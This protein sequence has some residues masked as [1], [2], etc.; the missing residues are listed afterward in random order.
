MKGIDMGWL[1]QWGLGLATALVAAVAAVIA[2]GGPSAL[3]PK[4]SINQPFKDQDWS[5]LP[6]LKT[7]PARDRLPLAYREYLPA[8][9]AGAP[10]EAARRDG[11]VLLVHGSSAHSA[12]MHSLAQG[13]AAMGWRVVTLDVRG[14]GES[15]PHGHIAYLGQLE[16]DLADLVAGQA[17]QAAQ[18]GQTGWPRPLR[19]AGFSAG[20]GL[21][22]RV[23]CGPL[24]D[25]FDG[26]LML[27]PFLGQDD[28]SYRPDAG[29]WVSVGV[30]RLL[31]LQALHKVGLNTFQHLPVMRFAVAPG[32]FAQLTDAYDWPLAS[33]FRPEPSQMSQLAFCQRPMQVV[34]GARDEVFQTDRY[35]ASFQAGG[36]P[37]PVTLVPG[38]DHV[39][40]ILQP[41]ARPAI[42][43]ALLAL[44]P[45]SSR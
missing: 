23:A 18:A 32:G 5:G 30:P 13:L 45:P 15:G 40:L 24:Q 25:L 33:N 16:D 36:K 1:W 28:P 39:G 42:D 6:P 14:H 29:G 8:A 34:A 26:Y 44:P 35:A 7:V 10:A 3:P 21:A 20:G 12:S 2:W 17:A 27:S 4:A 19:L 43:A 22:L 9:V 37:L 11:T 38:L 31:V 41:Q